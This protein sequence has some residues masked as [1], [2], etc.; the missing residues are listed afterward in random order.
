M[1]NYQNSIIYKLCCKN[2]DVTDIYIGSTTCFKARKRN[3]KCVCNN[4]KSKSYNCKLY[5]FIRENDGFENWNMIQ[6][7]TV[8]CNSKREL[9]AEERICIE[10][11]KPSLNCQ[12]PTRTLKEYISD[13]KEHIKQYYIDNKEHIK[14]YY[15]QYNVDNADKL[16]EYYTQYNIDNKEKRKKYNIDNKEKRKKYNIDN[17]EKKKEYDKQRYLKKK[18]E[19]QELPE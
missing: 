18:L 16:K 9:E 12:I 19:K 15:K 7:K 2:L 8:S 14:E 6:I 13:N 17:K 11:L 1:V 4:E 5:K 3:H 10:E